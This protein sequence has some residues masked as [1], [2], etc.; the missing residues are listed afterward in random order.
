MSPRMLRV[1]GSH[2]DGTILWMASAS[3]IESRIVPALHA[4][5]Q[6]AGRPAPRVV[7]GLPV[8]VHDD[9]AQARIACAG[10]AGSYATVPAY[11]RVLEAAGASQ[12]LRKSDTSCH[13][14]GRR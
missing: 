2:A 12:R 14:R 11:R 13:W 9:V 4:A 1:A 5:A 7:A 6:Q 10:T 8:A 3:V